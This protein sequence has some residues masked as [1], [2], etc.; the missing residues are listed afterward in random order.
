MGAQIG[1]EYALGGHDVALVARDLDAVRSR[2]DAASSLLTE[3]GLVSHDTASEANDRLRLSSDA[4]AAASGCAVIVE[5]LPEDFG[6]KIEHLRAAA[7]AAPDALVASNTSSLRI[8][9]LGR[10]AETPDRIVGMHYWNPP[11]LMPLVEIIAGEDTHPERLRFAAGLVSEL[12]KTPVMVQAD[13]PGF[14]WNRLQSAILREAVWLVKSGAV[15]PP[16]LDRVVSDGL[17][18]RWRHVGLLQSVAL[19]GLA[20]WNAAARQIVPHLSN[21]TALPDLTEVAIESP[22]PEAV[23]RDRDRQLACELLSSRQEERLGPDG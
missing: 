9:D 18:R 8:T 5:S 14:V 10:G 1:Y 6:L 22:D 12:G 23:I 17:A 20:T 21:V 7:E 11:L 13:I 4:A 19:G 3:S 16:D 15:S 2:V